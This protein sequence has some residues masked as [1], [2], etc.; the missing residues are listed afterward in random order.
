MSTVFVAH[1]SDAALN[2]PEFIIKMPDPVSGTDVYYYTRAIWK[3]SIADAIVTGDDAKID[4]CQAIAVEFD[5]RVTAGASVDA[6]KR[7][8]PASS[9]PPGTQT[10][11]G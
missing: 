6:V 3:Y 1:A 5:D 2:N 8:T 10:D 7:Q 9:D 11:P 4:G